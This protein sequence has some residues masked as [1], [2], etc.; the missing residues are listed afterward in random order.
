MKKVIILMLILALVGRCSHK[1]KN[2]DI[3]AHELD[4]YI[5]SFVRDMSGKVPTTSRNKMSMKFSDLEG[6]TVGL[7]TYTDVFGHTRVEFD[8]KAWNNYSKMERLELA[9]HEFSHALCNLPHSW[10][11]GIYPEASKSGI[12]S[13]GLA[14]DGYYDDFCPV[15][16][17]HPYTIEDSCL[18]K[19]WGEYIKDLRDRCFP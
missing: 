3:P 17:M 16:I 2:K 12:K 18:K 10:E 15:S 6:N 14:E 8:R 7:C 19:H 11:G 1:Q 5:D 13:S 4:G 9:Y